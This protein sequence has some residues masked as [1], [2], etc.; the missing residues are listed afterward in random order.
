[1]VVRPPLGRGGRS[2]ALAGGIVAKVTE[3]PATVD[4]RYH[5]AVIFDL[6]SVVTNI[7]PGAVR[8]LDSTVPMLRRLRDVGIASAVYS[9]TGNCADALRDAGIDELGRRNGRRSRQP[10]NARFGAADCSGWP[11]GGPSRSLR[12][13]RP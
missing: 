2:K 7:D 12:G 3:W 10:W 4:R 9:P 13:C 6:D 1:M 11:P 5:D 8:A